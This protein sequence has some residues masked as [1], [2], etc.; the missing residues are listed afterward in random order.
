MINN[1]IIAHIQIIQESLMKLNGGSLWKEKGIP[2][3][4]GG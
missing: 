1:N 3:K 4:Y 2:L